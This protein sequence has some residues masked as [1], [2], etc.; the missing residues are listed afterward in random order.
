MK[1]YLVTIALQFE[2]SCWG[3]GSLTDS[4]YDELGYNVETY[5]Q[6][7]ADELQN[8]FVGNVSKPVI[9]QIK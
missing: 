5:S 9:R 7:V 4:I 1:T 6:L 3:D 2:V 8:D